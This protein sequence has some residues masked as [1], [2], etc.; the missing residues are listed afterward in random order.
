MAYLSLGPQGR[1]VGH[2]D[3][4]SLPKDLGLII[5]LVCEANPSD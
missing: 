3:L 5:F 4:D 1:S 2:S